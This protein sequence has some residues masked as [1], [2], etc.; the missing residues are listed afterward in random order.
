M[1]NLPAYNYKGAR[2]LT[3]L[4]EDHMKSFLR[5]WEKAKTAN[6]KLPETEDEDY[7]SLETI[8]FH[9]LRAS[10]RYMVWICSKLN[11]SD[12]Q[13]D[14]PPPLSEIQL[15]S[16]EYL[17]HLLKRWRLPLVDVPEDLFF[18]TSYKSNW[19]DEFCIDAMLEHAVM[20]PIRH[21]FQ[22]KNLIKTAK[23]KT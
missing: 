15:K 20:H 12:P 5:A 21:E 22:L 16:G 10:M 18:G 2:S 7:Q 8:L 14:P 13:I 11:L 6:I 3:L 19:G 17:K 1:K 4:H 9:V 23:S